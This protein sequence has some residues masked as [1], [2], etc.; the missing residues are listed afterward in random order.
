MASSPPEVEED[1]PLIDNQTNAFRTSVIQ[2]IFRIT[3]D[4]KYYL[5]IKVIYAVLKIAAIISVISFVHSS[6][7]KLDKPL[8][9][10][11]SLILGVEIVFLIGNTY[12]L[13]TSPE[14][15]DI[16]VVKYLVILQNLGL[17]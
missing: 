11:V 13:L 8:I 17:L 10:F 6:T 15:R 9:V 2:T 16:K 3:D 12:N 1:R 4:S 14:E 5:Y 7:D